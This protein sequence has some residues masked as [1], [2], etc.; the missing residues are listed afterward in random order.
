MKFSLRNFLHR[1][2]TFSLLGS[3]VFLSNPVVEHRHCLFLAQ[4]E[5][6]FTSIQNSRQIIVLYVLVFIVLDSKQENNRFWTKW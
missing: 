6:V 2:V 5:T 1:S 4:C 3:N